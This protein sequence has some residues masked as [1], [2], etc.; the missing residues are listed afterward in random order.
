MAAFALAITAYLSGKATGDAHPA[1]RLSA[2]LFV[3]CSPSSCSTSSRCA[4]CSWT[5]RSIT[6]I[7]HRRRAPRRPIARE[8]VLGGRRG[9]RSWSLRRRPATLGAGWDPDPAA[10]SSAR[11]MP[12]RSTTSTPAV[13]ARSDS[14]ATTKF[15]RNLVA[16]PRP[17]AV[18]FDPQSD[19]MRIAVA[20]MPTAVQ[21]LRHFLLIRAHRLAP[22]CRRR[23]LIVRS[24]RCSALGFLVRRRTEPLDAGRSRGRHCVGLHLLYRARARAPVD[25][26]PCPPGTNPSGQNRY[27][28]PFRNPENG[29]ETSPAADAPDRA[30]DD[31]GE[32]GPKLTIRY[33]LRSAARLRPVP[34]QGRAI[35]LGKR[36]R[37]ASA[38]RRGRPHLLPSGPRAHSRAACRWKSPRRADDATN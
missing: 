22:W 33:G 18:P 6:L 28:K 12:T 38:A 21:R 24:C 35:S 7:V 37:P 30:N 25:R 9:P 27:K 19:E 15:P 13:L 26:F 4:I 36:S 5:R 16:Q 1:A 2:W 32:E 14:D 20:L 23:S 17:V 34:D 11:P 31:I 29:E 10:S 8:L 3:L